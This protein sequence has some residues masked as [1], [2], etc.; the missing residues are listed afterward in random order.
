MNKILSV[1]FIM[2]L[3]VL[4]GCA[5]KYVCDDGSTVTDP[6]MCA[7]EEPE[8]DEEEEQEILII[9]EEKEEPK[10]EEVKPVIKNIDKNVKDLFDKVREEDNF[11]YLYKA[12][13]NAYTKKVYVMGDYIREVYEGDQYVGD[14]GRLSDN[15]YDTIYIDTSKRTAYRMCREEVCENT[16]LAKQVSYNEFYD[17][18]FIGL[19]DSVVIAKD[20]DRSEMVEGRKTIVIDYKLENNQEGRMWIDQW[21][22]IPMK[23]EYADSDGEKTSEEF[24]GYEPDSVTEGMVRMP[25]IAVI[26]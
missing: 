3:L 8:E 14:D 26:E 6:L 15:R 17:G 24:S 20:T 12:P 23:L 21:Y 18:T 7:A 9:E 25:A 13:K 19:I 1:V 2:L 11:Q 22:G 4:G 16:T 10:A 5:T